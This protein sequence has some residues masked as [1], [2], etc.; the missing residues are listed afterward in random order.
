MQDFFSYC[1]KFDPKN[2]QAILGE[3]QLVRFKAG[4][5]IYHQGERSDAFYAI[6][7]GSVEIIVAGEQG[8]NPIPI[9]YMTKGDIF[10]EMGLLTGMPRNGTARV[11]DSAVVLKFSRG[12]FERLIF[13]VPSFAFYIA[14]LLARRLQQ[15]TVQLHFYSN[16][17][18]LAGSLD[19]FDLPTIF[20]TI[21]LSQQHGVMDVRQVTGELLGQFVF[22]F[23]KPIQAGYRHLGGFD[24]LFDFFQAPPQA[25]FSFA[26]LPQPPEVESPIEIRDVNEMLM[27]ALR[28]RDELH[29]LQEGMNLDQPLGRV[30]A[31]YEWTG[32]PG[33]KECA[34]AIWE[35]LTDKRLSPSE[36][37]DMLPYARYTITHVIDHLLKNQQLSAAKMT[38]YGYR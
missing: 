4:D 35:Q 38:S 34:D 28:Q 5:T 7:E 15:T 26:S 22:A 13:G 1:K 16:T 24:A 30:H 37:Y 27:E 36:L 20:Q 19:F 3:G 11:P 23:G 17:R 9:A 2:F 10:G 6:N 25:T 33:L 32:D 12:G 14:C 8:E 18:E 21:S 31:K 29:A